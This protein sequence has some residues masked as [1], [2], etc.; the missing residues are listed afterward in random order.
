MLTAIVGWGF[1][2]S[3]IEFGLKYIEPV[4]YLFFR[5]ILTTIII[6]FVLLPIKYKKIVELLKLRITWIIGVSEFFGL[7]FQFIAISY[8]ISAGLAALLSLLFLIIV[9][10]LSVVFL[11]ET[12]HPI[13]MLAVF[14]AIFGV[15]VITTNGDFSSFSGGSILAISLLLLSAFSYGMYIVFTSKL[16][17]IIKPD[18]D[19]LALFYV[20]M[21]IISIFSLLLS[22]FF[23]GISGPSF[24]AWKWIVYISV[25]ATI[26]PFI[27]Y[28]YAMK[29]YSANLA[30]IFLLGQIFVPFYID[31]FYLKIKYSFW[32]V[33]GIIV[34]IT[35]MVIAI[36]S[37]GGKE[38]G[39]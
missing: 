20:V 6:S 2:T 9:P 24:D 17:T 30:S 32:V 34:L 23:G 31:V 1:S 35:A 29:Y 22:F 18:T 37:E 21:L 25:L 33:G 14:L 16:S 28:F 5:F 8:N 38:N 26:A 11:N 3:F 27:G 13:H 10:F 12:I 36:L 39:L 7:A 4:Q 19:P 15:L